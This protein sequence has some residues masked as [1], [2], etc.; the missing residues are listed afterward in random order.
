V[1][2]RRKLR[3]VV[4]CAKCWQVAIV[5]LVGSG[6]DGDDGGD[7]GCVVVA[8][9]EEAAAPTRTVGWWM[10]MRMWTM[11]MVRAGRWSGGG[12]GRGAA[13]RWW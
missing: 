6:D 10:W 3:A 2:G 1:A 4:V 8:R 9:T 12:L 11:V 5:V 13:G 7:V